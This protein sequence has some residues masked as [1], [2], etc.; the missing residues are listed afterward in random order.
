LIA[1]QKAFAEFREFL[2]GTGVGEFPFLSRRGL[3]KHHE[4]L[5]R[6]VAVRTAP[7]RRQIPEG[8]ARRNLPD[9]IAVLR[10]IYPP[11]DAALEAGAVA[12]ALAVAEEGALK[13]IHVR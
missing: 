1:G 6:G 11:A 13:A 7:V 12:D 2:S 10:V 3:A 5:R 9:R 8:R 4:L